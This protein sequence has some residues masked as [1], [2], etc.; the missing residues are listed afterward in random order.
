[1]NVFKVENKFVLTV[2]GGEFYAFSSE[3]EA[4][5]SIKR[6]VPTKLWEVPEI[7]DR[8][9]FKGEEWIVET[10]F[11]EFLCDDKKVQ[12]LHFEYCRYEP[13]YVRGKSE[14]FITED[15]A[16]EKIESLRKTSRIREYTWDAAIP[17]W[18]EVQRKKFY[19]KA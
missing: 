3:P 2:D 12:I 8:A 14:F 17:T 19:R 9:I 5:I 13:G 4:I 18:R 15:Y 7:K 16:K 6:P 10:V 11:R 1:M